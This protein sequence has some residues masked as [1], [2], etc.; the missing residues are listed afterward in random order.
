MSGG[1][2]GGVDRWLVIHLVTVV[3]AGLYLLLLGRGQWFYLDEWAFLVRRGVFG[4]ER[5]LFAPHNEHWTT[6]PILAY[7]SVFAVFGVRS[8][9]PYFGLVVAAHLTLG[10]L[11]YR[12]AIRSGASPVATT[13]LLVPFLL[14]GSGAENTLSAFQISF[15]G[16]VVLGVAQLLVLGD[17]DRAGD[18]PMPGRRLGLLWLL[19]V[20]ALATSGLGVTMAAV[21]AGATLLRHGWRTAVRYVS[22][23]AAVQLV[24]LAAIGR[25]G[26]DSHQPSASNLFLLPRYT[27]TGVSSA[28][29]GFLGFDGSGPVVVVALAVALLFSLRTRPRQTAAPAALLLGVLVLYAINAIGRADFGLGQAA[30]GRYVYV[31]VALALPALALVVSLGELQPHHRHVAVAV[32]ATLATLHQ[33]G[34]LREAASA[35][36]E[37]ELDARSEILAAAELLREGGQIIDALP[38]PDHAPDLT[39]RGLSTLVR[40]GDIDDVDAPTAEAMAMARLR[41]Q[42]AMHGEA[43]SAATPAAFARPAPGPCQAVPSSER[44][45]V[46]V[47][48][49]SILRLRPSGSGSLQVTVDATSA[50]RTFA[51]LPDQ[52]NFLHVAAPLRLGLHAPPPA[53]VEV[54]L[55]P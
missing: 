42:V 11:L 29:G 47:A 37:I 26:L 4:A 44:L 55:A 27:W 36:S 1:R 9:L 39:M 3:A 13:L 20:L 6:V 18:G 24:W 25:D 2:A 8:Y 15:V 41:L 28:F 31:A 5:S 14:T 23:P 52:P 43:R 54:C 51:L 32:V 16:A 30:S 7:R 46:E 40:D 33:V 45:L 50:E 34:L 10:H 17:G 22:V 35:S 21:V 48:A 53:A 19:S 49:G 12:L 38:A